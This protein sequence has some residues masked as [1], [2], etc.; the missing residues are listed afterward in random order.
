AFNRH[1]FVDDIP[2]YHDDAGIRCL[3]IGGAQSPD[4]RSIEAFS[5]AEAARNDIRLTYVALTRAQAQVVAWWSPARDEPNGGL[6][7]LL[8]G[9][10][11]REP[12]VPNR[13]VPQKMCAVD[14][15]ALL[16]EW[17]AAGGPVIES[18]VVAAAPPVPVKSAPPD[19]G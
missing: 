5:R 14:A 18:S 9:R 4:R 2:L 19:L 6:S 12:C 17:E 3:D 15:M 1:V 13:C 16:R 11:P 8:R 7:R 10:R